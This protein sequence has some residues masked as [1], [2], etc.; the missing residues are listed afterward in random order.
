MIF[1]YKY[2]GQSGIVNTANRVGISFAPDLLREPTF[3]VGNLNQK[4]PFREAMSALHSVVVSDL[5]FQPKD[6]TEYKEWAKQQEEIWLA[7]YM[8]QQPDLKERIGGM[9]TELNTLRAHKQKILQPFNKAKWAFFKYIRKRD[10]DAWFVLDPVITVHPDELF[11]ECFSQD[12]STY[13][14]LACDYN[15]FDK[16]N[17]FECGT[18]NI[19]YSSAL[20]NEFQKIRTYK[21]TQFKIDPSGFEVQTEGEDDYKEEKIDLPDTW[22]RG[23]L[24]VSTAMTLPAVSFELHPMDLWNVLFLLR[25]NKAQSS[26]R[27]M[28]YILK[29]GEPIRIRFKPWDKEITCVRSIYQGAEAREIKVW[30]RRRL[31]TL[32][33]LMPIAQSV[34]V[35]LLGDGLP[36]FYI[37]GMDDLHFTLGLS[38][39]TSN[40]W[41]RTGQF[42]LMGSMQQVDSTSKGAIYQALRQSWSLTTD[43]L[44][45][46]TGFD[47]ATV[48]TAMTAHAQEGNAIFDLTKNCYR[49]RELSKDGIPVEKLRYSSPLEEQ[50]HAWQQAGAVR[51][52]SRGENKEVR[53]LKG[54]VRV[55][56]TTFQSEL[57]IN[58]DQKLVQATCS[59]TDFKENGL[60][61]GP[62]A[63]LLAVR[64]QSEFSGL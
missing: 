37:V 46:T 55:D 19:D 21:D 32:E 35:H 61:K 42:N 11:F 2:G 4:I 59:C 15:V 26:P 34:K 23:F 52:L 45:K 44:S 8:A 1:N 22:V 25:R 40:D 38:G 62:C 60:R 63:H 12:E 36:S 53:L 47:K 10:Y 48:H 41:S 18:T 49:A 14:R 64:I 16:I 7:E 9:K 20:Y 54:E 5:R 56:D 33:R 17:T 58:E 6:K 50:A 28:Q 57:T 29:P 13:A 51:I 39:W 30:G 43:E 31:L 24:Q 27:Y 3:F